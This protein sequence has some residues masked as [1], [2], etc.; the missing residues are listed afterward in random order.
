MPRGHHWI[1]GEVW[2]S[3]M[4]RVAVDGKRDP[5]SRGRYDTIVHSNDTSFEAGPIVKSENP[6][7]GK[8]VK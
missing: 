1:M 2:H 4:T 8:A 7:H 6:S 3:G 5:P